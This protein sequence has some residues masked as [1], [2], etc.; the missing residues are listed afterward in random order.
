MEIFLL[1]VILLILIFDTVSTVLVGAA[2]A[3]NTENIEA[4]AMVLLQSRKPS[5]APAGHRYDPGSQLDDLQTQE[6]LLEPKPEDL[7]ELRK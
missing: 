3:R 6:T 5:D 7:P 4:I 2:T 1:T